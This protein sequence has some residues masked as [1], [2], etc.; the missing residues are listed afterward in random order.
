MH[1]ATHCSFVQGLSE[2]VVSTPH[3]VRDLLARGNHARATSATKMNASSSRSHAVFTLH[4][5]QEMVTTKSRHHAAT[6]PARG[7]S[8]APATRGFCGDGGKR[9]GPGPLPQMGAA[10]GEPL[11]AW[12][13]TEREREA[14]TEEES[15]TEEDEGAAGGGSGGSGGGAGGSGGLTVSVRRRKGS[16]FSKAY[17]EGLKA[18]LTPQARKLRSKLNL[19]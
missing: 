12:V 18:L 14:L 4:L 6:P 16:E 15:D 2:H 1:H 17:D 8:P 5:Q 19:V 3:E 11:D 7:G 13:E 10:G 9:N